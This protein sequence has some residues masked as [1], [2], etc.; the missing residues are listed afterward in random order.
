MTAL[1][2]LALGVLAAIFVGINI[3]GSSTGVAFGPAVG[4]NILSKLAAGMLMTVFALIGG[5]TVGRN[6]VTTMGGRI[7]P[8]S[9]FT[10]TA[11]IIVLFFVGIGLLISNLVGVPASTS[12]TAVGAIAGLGAATGSIDWSVM[13]YIASWWIVAPV[14]A[15]W[16]GG[17]IGRYVYPHLD[18]K[19]SLHQSD[20]PLLTVIRRYP[21][22]IRGPGTTYREL[23][24]A[25]LIVGIACFMAFSAGASN[26]ANAVAP[27]VGSN[28]LSMDT[29]V[30]LAI[31][32]ISCGGFTIARRTLDTVGDGLTDLPLL[33]ALIVSTVSASIITSLSWM[34]VPASLAISSTMCITGL[35]WGRATRTVTIAD[36]V[37]GERPDTL[38]TG[39]L[40]A[41]NDTVAKIGDEQSE[42]LDRPALFN[43]STTGTVIFL[44][45]LTPTISATASFLVFTLLF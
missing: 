38:S 25:T 36:T 31:A 17:A 34:G 33:A 28:A 27:L 30:L 22:V 5:W 7:V 35:G 8:S 18:R 44:W 37:K 24:G 1:L 45:I 2:I 15:F 29:G 6:V 21:F 26:V 39:A 32:A 9:Q 3:G 19:A 42:N 43:P 40:A 41:E 23:G 14:I 11:S 20:G 13:G 4:S 10:L 16:M 12:M